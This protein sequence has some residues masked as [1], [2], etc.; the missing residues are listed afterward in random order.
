MGNLQC[1]ISAI[2]KAVKVVLK[3]V[4]KGKENKG[5][6]LHLGFFAALRE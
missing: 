4:E 6:P 1:V 5:K 2:Q 3:G